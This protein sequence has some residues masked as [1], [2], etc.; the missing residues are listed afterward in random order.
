MSEVS[1]GYPHSLLA[2]PDAHGHDGPAAGQRMP[3]T[4][5][6]TPVG[7][8]DAPRFVLFGALDPAS[9][10][11]LTAYAELLEPDLRPPFATGY[12]WLVR[13]DSYVACVARAGDLRTI[14]DYLGAIRLTAGDGS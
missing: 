7:A 8:G 1:V 6:A 14:A 5:L 3:P 2:G 11:L 10:Q 12:V 13:P 9:L 4:L